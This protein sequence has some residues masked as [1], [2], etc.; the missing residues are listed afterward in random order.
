MSG[1]LMQKITQ[2]TYLGVLFCADLLWRID[3][4]LVINAAN[5]IEKAI[6]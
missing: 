1:L 5:S 4:I 2:F 3:V 6:T